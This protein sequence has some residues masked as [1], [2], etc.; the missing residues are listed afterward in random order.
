MKTQLHSPAGYAYPR[1]EIIASI[2]SSGATE[3]APFPWPYYAW[4]G[5]IGGRTVEMCGIETRGSG[6]MSRSRHIA[7]WLDGRLIASGP[8]DGRMSALADHLRGGQFDNIGRNLAEHHVA[9]AGRTARGESAPIPE[10]FSALLA[11]GYTE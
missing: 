9:D 4:C 8:A 6:C 10:W 3:I 7:V 1:P 11:A 5:S 2:K